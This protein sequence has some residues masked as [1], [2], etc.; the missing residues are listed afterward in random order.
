MYDQQNKKCLSDLDHKLLREVLAAIGVLT[1]GFDCNYN[2]L[3]K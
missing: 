2:L 1:R 3:Q